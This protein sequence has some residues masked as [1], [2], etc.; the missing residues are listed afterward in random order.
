MDISVV[1]G[2]A[3]G[4]GL[5][6]AAWKDI[7][8]RRVP[9]A[10][11]VVLAVMGTLMTAFVQGGA[12]LLQQF[13]V[14]FAVFLAL[15][16]PWRKGWLGAADVKLHVVMALWLSPSHFLWWFL[17]CGLAGGFLALLLWQW[18]SVRQMT[19]PF[20]IRH[21]MAWWWSSLRSLPWTEVKVP[22]AVAI[23]C[24]YLPIYWD[25]SY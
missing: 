2:G 21:S 18:L 10:L 1:G 12:S 22:Y 7:R 20:T 19:V 24:G 15:W 5:F 13:A 14:A 8:Y 17:Y 9:N 6:M 4:I 25:I 3:L 11:I 23:F 16:V